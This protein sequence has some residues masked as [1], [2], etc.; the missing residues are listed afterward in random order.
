MAQGTLPAVLIGRLLELIEFR[1]YLTKTQPDAESRWDNVQELINF[2]AECA[3]HDKSSR[4][5]AS[6]KGAGRGEERSNE[7][8]DFEKDQS[9]DG[10]YSA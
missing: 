1:E 10:E 5:T 4:S 9:D 8:D 6:T 3:I 7:P 2:A